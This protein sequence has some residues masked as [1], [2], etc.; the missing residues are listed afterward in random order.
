MACT[1]LDEL[2][3]P[4]LDET[5]DYLLEEGCVEVLPLGDPVIEFQATVYPAVSLGV[6]T[7][8]QVTLAAAARI[9]VTTFSLKSSP[10]V[11]GFGTTVRGL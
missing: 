4:L 7:S 1:L 10:Q 5:G 2:G 8:A 9:Q 3:L 11:A 6:R